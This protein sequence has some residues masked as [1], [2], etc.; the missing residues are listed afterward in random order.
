[1]FNKIKFPYFV[2]YKTKTQKIQTFKPG[3][4]AETSGP[5]PSTH[6]YSSSFCTLSDSWIKHSAVS[7]GERIILAF[8]IHRNKR[9]QERKH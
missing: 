3:A 5:R 6:E 7:G 8:L 4:M 2:L 9:N 1:M